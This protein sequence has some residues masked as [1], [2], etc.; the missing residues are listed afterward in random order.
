VTDQVATPDIISIFPLIRIIGHGGHGF[1]YESRDAKTVRPVAVKVLIAHDPEVVQHFKDEARIVGAL[2]HPNIAT[3]YGSGEEG[4]KLY[5]VLELVR[6][7]TLHNMMQGPTLLPLPEVCHIMAQVAGGVQHAHARHVLHRDLKPTNIMV[8]PDGL[9]KILD[10]GISRSTSLTAAARLN[11]YKTPDGVI[12]GT[13]FYMAPEQFDGVEADV[14]TDIFSFGCMLYELVTGS[15]PFGEGATIQEYIARVN[16]VDALPPVRVRPECPARLNELVMRC[17]ERD[18]ELR[19]E[20]FKD[21]RLGIEACRTAFLQDTIVTLLEE[22][23]HLIEQG[24]LDAAEETVQ[25]ALDLD[26]HNWEALQCHE[27]IRE[28]RHLRVIARRVDTVL[29]ASSEMLAEG[30]ISDAVHALKNVARHDRENPEVCRRLAEAEDKLSS[31]NLIYEAEFHWREGREREAGRLV[32]DALRL[33]PENARARELA[34]QIAEHKRNDKVEQSRAFDCAVR[35]ISEDLNQGHLDDAAKKLARLSVDSGGL[36]G[37]SDILAELRED[38]HGR[39]RRRVVGTFRRQAVGAN[40]QARQQKPVTF[41]AVPLPHVPTSPLEALDANIPTVMPH[42]EQFAPVEPSNAEITT[43]LL[44]LRSSAQRV[45]AICV[46]MLLLL[47]FLVSSRAPKPVQEKRAPPASSIPG[48]ASPISAARSEAAWIPAPLAIPHGPRKSSVR[49]TRSINQRPPAELPS[50]VHAS[51]AVEILDAPSVT[52]I[53]AESIEVAGPGA[54]VPAPPP[55]PPPLS[56]VKGQVRPPWPKTPLT[57]AYPSAARESKIA[58]LVLCD[59][60]VSPAGQT[61]DISCS[62]NPILLAAASQAIGNRTY[63]PATLSDI[64]DGKWQF[65]PIGFGRLQVAF[66]FVLPDL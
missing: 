48:A 29:A 57:I 32:D 10:F 63:G 20:N 36:P 8:Q 50:S 27:T 46:V 56:Y 35:E 44:R 33:D 28:I 9:V 64:I 40:P 18:R 34:G 30:R 51:S 61:E 16:S 6:G 1:V 38:L 13:I 15:H 60:R 23:S 24:S 42:A 54:V 41:K 22:A 25:R 5:Q 52:H 17:L 55:P 37:A 4:G 53:A 65:D 14:R 7:K 43:G 45:V 66:H 47:M 39:I 3:L 58:G 11:T 19:L 59:F 12:L 26:N 31:Q 62:G 49:E 2:S 21:V